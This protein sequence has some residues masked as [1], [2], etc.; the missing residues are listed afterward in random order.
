MGLAE[1]VAQL[2]VL[3]Q[4]AKADALNPTERAEYE[5]DRE[6]LALMLLNAQKIGLKA[7]ETARRAIRANRVL[8]IEL[9]A[10]SKATKAVTLEVSSTGFSVMLPPLSP[11]WQDIVRFKMKLPGGPEVLGKAKAMSATPAAGHVRVGFQIVEIADA[12]REQ[13]T[14]IVFDDILDKLRRGSGAPRK[15]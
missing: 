10:G 5:K 8:P 1:Y 11:E 13:L 3:H 9:T 15:P 14:L 7:G 6:D 2:T 12:D 4:K